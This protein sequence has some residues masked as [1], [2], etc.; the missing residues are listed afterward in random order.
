[1]KR[2][3]VKTIALGLIAVFLAAYLMVEHFGTR[4][5]DA[6]GAHFGAQADG[7][8]ML[9]IPKKDG[10]FAL[11]D[12]EGKIICVFGTTRMGYLRL[13]AN[14]GYADDITFRDSSLVKN[15]ESSKGITVQEARLLKKNYK[16]TIGDK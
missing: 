8:I 6:A 2:E 4:N 11:T 7:I 16:D 13:F 10:H 5:A 15:I 3:L 12:P 1:M 14:R 9:S